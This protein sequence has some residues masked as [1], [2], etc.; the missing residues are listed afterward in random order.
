MRCLNC[1]SEQV[2]PAKSAS[3]NRYI[4][5]EGDENRNPVNNG[6]GIFVDPIICTNCGY[7]QLINED[8]KDVQI[9]HVNPNFSI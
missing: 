3:G 4:L 2:A 9:T 6:K 7:I 5:C 8:F 1:K